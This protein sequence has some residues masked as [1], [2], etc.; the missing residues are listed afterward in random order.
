MFQIVFS[1]KW[2]TKNLTKLRNSIMFY[3][4]LTKFLTDLFHKSNSLSYLYANSDKFLYIVLC[5]EFNLFCFHLSCYIV[6]KMTRYIFSVLYLFLLYLSLKPSFLNKSRF[7]DVWIAFEPLNIELQL[8][9]FLTRI[10]T[11]KIS[12]KM[13]IIRLN[14]LV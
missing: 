8:R 9:E 11:R 4:K 12:Q 7:Y 3:T 2:L 1:R 6:S 13:Q 14:Y 10:N 5:I